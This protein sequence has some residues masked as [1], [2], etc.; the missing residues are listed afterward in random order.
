[1]PLSCVTFENGILSFT[2]GAADLKLDPT[3]D[4]SSESNPELFLTQHVDFDW[5]I[6]FDAKAVSG[7]VKLHLMPVDFYAQCRDT[8]VCFSCYSHSYIRPSTFGT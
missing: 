3:D 2:Q 6:D 8:L 4:P 5:K 7:C 1:M